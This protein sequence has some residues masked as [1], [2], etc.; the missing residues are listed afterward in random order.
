MRISVWSSDVCSS[1]LLLNQHPCMLTRAFSAQQRYEC[2]LPRVRI[3]MQRLARACLVALHVKTVVSDLESK[4]HI[5]RIDRKSVGSGKSVSVRVDLGGR[6]LL[7]KKI[8]QRGQEQ[9]TIHI[10]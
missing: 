3:L 9:I 8:L 1:D 7:N 4:P 10:K 5:P 2:F 6:R